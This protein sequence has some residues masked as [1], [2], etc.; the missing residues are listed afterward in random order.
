MPAKDKKIQ[1][2]CTMDSFVLV[3]NCI[4]YDPG[5]KIKTTSGVRPMLLVRHHTGTAPNRL[6]YSDGDSPTIFL[7]WALK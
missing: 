7:N 2:F 5:R 4:I 6:W 1:C 3:L